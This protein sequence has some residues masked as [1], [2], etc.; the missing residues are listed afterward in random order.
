MKKIIL[1]IAALF[2]LT[3][4][5]KTEY[6]V[7]GTDFVLNTVSTID[8]Y[9]YDG[10]EKPENIISSCFTYIRQLENELSRT[11]ET[12]DIARLNN[13]N[14]E[15]V[16]I[17]DETADV[18]EKSIHY[19]E[20]S[21]GAFDVTIARVSSLWDFTSGEGIVPEDSEIKAAI[22]TVGYENIELMRDKSGNFASLKNG[23]QIDLGAIAKGYIADKS[24]Q[25]LKENGVKAGIVN[26]GGNNLVFGEKE[27]GDP[28]RIGVQSPTATTGEF[29]GVISFK[30]MSAV[31]SGAYQRFF[32]KD[33]VTYHHILD[34]ETGYPAETD[35][36]SV[37]IIC[38]DSVD[39][40]A[41]STSAFILG[42]EQAVELMDSLDYACAVI[43]T[44]D[45]E[46]ILTD[47]AEK[48]YKEL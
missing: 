27:S 13:S 40:D 39:A 19:S 43:I 3:G 30:D 42:S 37:T 11:I 21:G 12:S 45:G 6:P 29:T 23:A 16:E 1:L 4:C 14:G 36:A 28:F 31:T 18:L 44:N 48:Y 32:V 38:K 20:L 7:S 25:F 24:A 10:N 46:T 26:L 9:A 35:I 15:V 2:C 34:P 47:G 33:G 17:S 41:L 5:Q 8:I 22:E